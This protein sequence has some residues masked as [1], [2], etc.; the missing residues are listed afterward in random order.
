MT[1]ETIARILT[2]RP[3]ETGSFASYDES[4]TIEYCI[5][6]L[7]PGALNQLRLERHA[8]LAEHGVTECTP[9]TAEI[10]DQDLELRVLAE[11]VRHPGTG[12]PLADLEEW[13]ET[14][15]PA[16]RTC[17]AHYTKLEAV[18]DVI[19]MGRADMLA[20][21]AAYVRQEKGPGKAAYWSRVDYETLLACFS[22]LALAHD[23]AQDELRGAARQLGELRAKVERLEAELDASRRKLAT[24]KAAGKRKRR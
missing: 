5:E 10:Y 7:P 2:T 11:A 12:E 13:R 21:L 15:G 24:M 1:P 22:A 17:L 9:A 20:D 4:E 16:V 3:S 19:D 6:L 14:Q 18:S 8:D 23:Q